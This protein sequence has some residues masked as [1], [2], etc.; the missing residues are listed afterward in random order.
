MY[1]VY[2][3]HCESF[4]LSILNAYSSFKD[5]IE[6]LRSDVNDFLI[7][8]KGIQDAISVN[9]KS[10]IKAAK[11]DGY[12]VKTSNKY[13]NRIS[14]YQRTSKDTGY[15]MSNM[16]I[17]VRKMM[18]FSAVEYS[19]SSLSQNEFAIRNFITTPLKNIPKVPYVL[20]LT[21]LLQERRKTIEGKS[22]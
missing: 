8:Y 15:I 9:K 13:P 5:S 3:I 10:E 18:V 19:T 4:C 16:E 7:N 17:T 21:K 14:L 6:H 2:S 1:I 20:E 22:D 12:F 11:T